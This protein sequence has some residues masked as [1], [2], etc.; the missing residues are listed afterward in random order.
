MWEF[1]MVWIGR[2][3]PVV[4]NIWIAHWA[5]ACIQQHEY[6]KVAGWIAFIVL[7]E[8]DRIKSKINLQTDRIHALHEMVRKSSASPAVPSR[9]R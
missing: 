9:C 1:I 2:L 4:I 6:A 5:Y 3:S 8:C 7:C